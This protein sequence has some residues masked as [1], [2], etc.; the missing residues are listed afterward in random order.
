[1]PNEHGVV[2]ED[3]AEQMERSHG[4]KFAGTGLRLGA[5]AGSEELGCTLYEVPPER[6]PVPYHYHT[7][8]EEAIYVLDGTGRL[9]TETEEIDISEGSY[10]ALPAGEDGAHQVINSSDEPLR[11]LCVST[12]NEP[13][14]MVYPD[15]NKVG[16]VAGA[17]PGGPRK[18][19]TLQK[20]FHA[21][22][23]VDYWEGE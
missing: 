2:H 6:S 5:T 23:D 22:S 9:R 3:E 21:D 1:M 19:V 16:M 15:S 4:E 10:V 11:F 7:A 18:K 12:M 14:V 13:D 17:A 8:N 20:M